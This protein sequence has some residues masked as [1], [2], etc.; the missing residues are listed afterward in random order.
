MATKRVSQEGPATRFGVVRGFFLDRGARN[1]K[2]VFAVFGLQFSEEE[3][4]HIENLWNARTRVEDKDL[5]I[6]ERME[7][8][9]ATI[10]NAA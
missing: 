9:V 8:V 6:I 4:K 10:R 7:R 1:Y 3:A 5:P 2:S